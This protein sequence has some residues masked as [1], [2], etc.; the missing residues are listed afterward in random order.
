M[1]ATNFWNPTLR[2]TMSVPSGIT[3]NK[4]NQKKLP[5]K[6]I[7]ICESLDNSSNN[8]HLAAENQVRKSI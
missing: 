4:E 7:T 3:N 2:K 8:N 1:D 6:S 5:Q